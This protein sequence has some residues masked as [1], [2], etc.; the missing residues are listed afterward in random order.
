MVSVVVP[1]FNRWDLTARC[2]AT[3]GPVGEL[4]LV[5]NGSTDDTRF[6][7]PAVADV[8]VRNRTNR[9]F[10]KGCNQGFGAAS[11]DVVVFLNNDT[12]PEPGW[13]D[14]LVGAFDDPRVV[15][16]GCRIVAPDGTVD[17]AGVHVDFTRPPGMEAWHATEGPT[18]DVEA[19]TGAVM[20]VR[21]SW[22][23]GF[24][25]GFWNGYEDVDCCLAATSMGW[26]VRY[27]AESTVMHRVSQSGPER[28]SKVAE[29][30][31][32]LRARWSE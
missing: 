1:C 28:W 13:L 10:A 25:E 5:D 8:V 20:A 24:H 26:K 30:V 11:G 3:V 32:L 15:I 31:A 21:G 22:F 23:T 17:H 29:N 14:G 7:G 6:A 19:V 12:E 9:G 18:R 4:V 2:L 16:A 27:V